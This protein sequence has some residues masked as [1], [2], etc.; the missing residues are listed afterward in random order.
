MTVDPRRGLDSTANRHGMWRMGTSHDDPE[1]ALYRAKG[2]WWSL[3][4]SNR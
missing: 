1:G 3:P 4:G 2:K